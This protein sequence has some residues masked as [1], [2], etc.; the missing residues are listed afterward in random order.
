V[1]LSKE[2]V[3][4]IAQ[5]VH[6]STSLVNNNE[7]QLLF[8]KPQKTEE[9]RFLNKHN[10]WDNYKLK[11]NNIIKK[12]LIQ[13]ILDGNT[14]KNTTIDNLIPLVHTLSVI[15]Q[16]SLIDSIKHTLSMQDGKL[17]KKRLH[18]IK[19]FDGN[20]FN[21]ADV[22]SYMFLGAIGGDILS[23]I[24]RIN[25]ILGMSLCAIASGML[26][27]ADA[28]LGKYNENQLW[29]QREKRAA[30][31]IETINNQINN[32]NAKLACHPIRYQ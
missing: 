3:N 25:P 14:P 26:V 2:L 10:F 28:E 5:S 29:D 12:A 31:I 7:Y 16:K 9:H 27:Y 19:E 18:A 15:E 17:T 11:G 20:G 8:N 22:A 4:E 32:E 13:Y 24:L 23:V 1:I 21:N 6:T 30:L